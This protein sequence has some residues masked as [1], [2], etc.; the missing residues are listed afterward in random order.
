MATYHLN[1]AGEP[2]KCSAQKGKCPFGSSAQHYADKES[3]RAAFEQAQPTSFPVPLT[4]SHGQW[5]RKGEVGVSD[6]LKAVA[7]K[8]DE[9]NRYRGTY[10]DLAR[11]TK[12]HLAQAEPGTGS[13]DGDVLL[14]PVPPEGFYTNIIEITDENR[15]LVEEIYEARRDGEA[16]VAKRIVKGASHAP[17]QVV[18]IVTYRADVLAKDDDRSTQDEWE[19]VA[20][21]AQPEENVPMHPTTMERNASNATGGTLRTYTDEQWAEARAYWDRHAFADE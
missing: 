10:E 16:P 6:F 5:V 9:N 1:E 12:A 21:L 20:I 2:G 8:R 4:L 17:A 13:Q 3:A 19:I 15:H 7:E 11:L 18:K 14:V